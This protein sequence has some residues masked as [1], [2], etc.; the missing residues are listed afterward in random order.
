MPNDPFFLFQNLLFMYVF[1]ILVVDTISI[2]IIM[3]CCT[4]HKLSYTLIT[5]VHKHW[6]ISRCV[7]KNV[8]FFFK[9]RNYFEWDENTIADLL[10]HGSNSEELPVGEQQ[11]PQQVGKKLEWLSKYDRESIPSDHH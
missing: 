4:V 8:Q 6:G 11:P 1:S 3:I 7:I 9:R 5:A 2:C 10:L